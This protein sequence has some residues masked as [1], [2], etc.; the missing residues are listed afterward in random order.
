MDRLS[1][2]EGC[3]IFSMGQFPRPAS[4][5][6]YHPSQSLPSKEGGGSLTVVL[7]FLNTSL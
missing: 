2:S 4:Q 3:K 6:R 7:D 5:R 1:A